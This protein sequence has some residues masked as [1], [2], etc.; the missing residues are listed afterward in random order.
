MNTY[1]EI[2]TIA[3][4]MTIGGAITGPCKVIGIDMDINNNTDTDTGTNVAGTKQIVP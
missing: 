4:F 2:N 3:E 1:A